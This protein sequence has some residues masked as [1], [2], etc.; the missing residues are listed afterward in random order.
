MTKTTTTVM[1][2]VVAGLFACS[3]EAPAP[4]KTGS[5]SSSG[6]S[7]SA[8]NPPTTTTDQSSTESEPCVPKGA[9]ANDKGVGAY[10]DK[11]TRCSQGAFCTADFGAP[12][13]AQ[14]CTLMCATDADCGSGAKCFEEARGKGCVPVACLDD[15]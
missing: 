10:C 5:S 9:K 1:A 7:G 14:F 2:V 6:A 15:K 12:V 11:A 3:S 4:T 8:A 13:G